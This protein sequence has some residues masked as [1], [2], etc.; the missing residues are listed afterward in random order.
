MF[1]WQKPATLYVNTATWLVDSQM[2][3]MVGSQV[4]VDYCC[5]AV[6]PNKAKRGVNLVGYLRTESG[7]GSAARGYHRALGKLGVPC[8]LND[9]SGLQGNRSL[10]ASLADQLVRDH[11]HDINLV[12][13]DVGLH[14]AIL[15]HLGEDFFENRYNVGIWAWELP[16]FPAKWFDRFGYYDEIWVASSFIANAL[17]AIAPVPVVRVPPVLTMPRRG[18]RQRG[19]AKLGVG[20]HEFVFLFVFDF[21]S[22]WQRKN[23]MAIVSAFRRAFASSDPVRLIIK[24]VNGQSRPAQLAQLHD[25][26]RGYP[27]SIFNGYWPFADVADLME[28]CDAYV[29]LHRAEGTGLTITDAMALG[30]PVIATGWSGNMDFMNVANSYPV[31]YKLVI[32]DENVGPYRAGETWADPSVDHAAELM[33]RVV[34]HPEEA[35]ALGQAALRDIENDYSEDAVAALLEERLQAIELRQRY[36]TFRHECKE[37]YRNYHRLPQHM[38]ELVRSAVPAGAR[39]LVVSKGDDVLID[40]GICEASHF[41]QDVTGGYAGFYP[42]DSSAAIAHLESLR[43]KG[44]D[45]LLL[46]QTAFWWLDHYA[47]FRDHLQNHY[48]QIRGNE[49]GL[50]YDLQETRR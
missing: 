37:K 25:A 47:G 40:L 19:R 34:E 11:P 2:H 33:R 50:L 41:P 29:S 45:Y 15:A 35:A 28:A 49:H 8:A 26:A 1:L 9:I 42:A 16:R 22:Y 13:A 27:I 44:A 18:V 32:L 36:R 7:V 31:R 39:V 43:A 48:A 6:A 3:S 20:L 21:H 5:E 38:T 24:C 23:P 30:K 12:C 10:D 46:P 14:Y 4:D 17:S